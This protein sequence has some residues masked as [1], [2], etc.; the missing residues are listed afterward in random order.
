MILKKPYALFIKM[1]KPIHLALSALVGYLF[2]LTNNILIFLNQYIYSSDSLISNEKLISLTNNFIYIIPIIIIIFFFLLIGVMY[3]K[4]K[5]MLFYFVGVFVFVVI[6]VINTYTI[7]FLGVISQNIVSVKVTKLIHDLVL[8]NLLLESVSF[9]LL[10]V[11]GIGIDFKKFDFNSDI[12]KFEVSESDREEF[13]VNI[14]VD[15]DERKRKRKEKLRNLK[16]LYVE[17]RFLINIIGIA[18]VVLM[19][20]VTSFILIKQMRTNKQ[21]VYYSAGSFD[22]MVNNTSILNTDYQGNKIT[23]NY[24]IVVNTNIKS[25]YSK[26]S[27]Y[28]N[29]FSLKIGNVKFKPTK[30]YADSLVD[31]GVLYTEQALSLEEASYVFIFEIPEKYINSEMYFSYNSKGDVIDILV[32]PKELIN[33]DKTVIKNIRDNIKL[34]NPLN[35]VEFKV[36]NYELNDMFVINY[37]Y[38]IKNDDCI[39]S[40]EYLRPSIDKNYDKV[41]LKLNVDYNSNNDLD[42]K[43]FYLLLSKFG[44]ISYKKNDTW[45]NIYNFEEIKSLRVSSKNDIYVGVHSNIIDADSIKL[46][47]NVR[48]LKYEY[49]LK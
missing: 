39:A 23:E 20:F 37:N 2:Y 11:R 46:V 44:S 14:N 10:F 45:N 30:K 27:L 1:F 29:D 36:N 5:P 49:I 4:K 22:F 26:N 18:I 21:G 32:Q 41:I 8:I 17:N 34:D 19:V 7:N 42:V 35:G 13:E 33:N 47:F 48:G 3:K 12:S 6:L 43:T 9:I 16:Y 24:L 31:L 40:K 38:C 25:S 15:F 28:L